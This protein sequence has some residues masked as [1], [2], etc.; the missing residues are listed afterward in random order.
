ML[1]ANQISG[2]LKIR[3]VGDSSSCIDKILGIPAAEK[4]GDN[5]YYTG[6]GDQAIYLY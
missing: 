4:L 6:P 1:I 5:S 3:E 2:F